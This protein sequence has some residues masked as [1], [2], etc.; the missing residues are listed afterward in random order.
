[1]IQERIN[2]LKKE[3]ELAENLLMENVKSISTGSVL[4]SVINSIKTSQNSTVA[5]AYSGSALLSVAKF[6]L[7]IGTKFYSKSIPFKAARQLMSLKK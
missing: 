5:S 4:S 3:S 1:M 2:K 6:A 7:A